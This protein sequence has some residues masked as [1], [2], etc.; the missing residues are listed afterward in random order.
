VARKSIAPAIGLGA[1]IAALAAAGCG[2]SSSGN[3][4]A[5]G[6]AAGPSSASN[7][8]SNGSG[9]TATEAALTQQVSDGQL[10]HY[11]DGVVEPGYAISQL[12]KYELDAFKLAAQPISP[13]EQQELNTCLNQS[14]CDTGHGTLTIAYADSFGL[15]PVRKVYR[16]IITLQ[17]LRYPQVKR[18]IYT[19]G[20]G[21]LSKTISNMRSLVAQKVNGIFGLFD[22]G[23]AMESTAR[24][25][26][27]QGIPVVSESQNIPTA[28]GHGD[29]AGDWDI[30]SCLQGTM[31]GQIAAQVKPHPSIAMYTGTPGNPFAGKWQPCAQKSVQSGA[32]NVTT[33]GTT[34]WSPQGEAQ[35]ASALISKGLPD[36]IVYD[37]RQTQF[38]SKILA[39]GKTPPAAVGGSNDFGW[40]KLWLGAQGTAHAFPGYL[41]QSQGGYYNVGI[42]ELVEKALH[43]GSEFPI[44]GVLPTTVVAAAKMRP[45]YDP[46]LPADTPFNSGLPS[47]ILAEALAAPTI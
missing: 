7:T 17:L 37:Y 28:T 13:A 1:V 44:H 30:N 12:P 31:S 45:F 24:L 38:D 16:A 20:A 4:S 32:G 29:I 41:T 14:P 25:A 47:S 23:A 2:S 34:N 43:Q 33:N 40:Y 18:I 10:Q 3:S 39:E 21:D 22:F 5:S 8:G 42:S 6:N 36:A 46:T 9:Q 35:A 11:I 19:D 27:A 26:A 15:N